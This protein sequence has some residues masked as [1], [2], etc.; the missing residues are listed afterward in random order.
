[1]KINSNINKIIFVLHD[2]GRHGASI[3]ISDFIKWIKDNNPIIELIVISSKPGVLSE[4]NKRLADNYLYYEGRDFWR[5][6]LR[7]EYVMLLPN[8]LD[9]IYKYCFR[10]RTY[11]KSYKIKGQLIL[12]RSNFFYYI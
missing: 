5:N 8:V 4:Q 2:E 10:R 11:L 6:L 7:N 12:T 9:G 3:L 1:M